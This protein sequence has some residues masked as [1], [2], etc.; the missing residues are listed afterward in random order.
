[1][2]IHGCTWHGATLRLTYRSVVDDVRNFG[3]Q[4]GPRGRGT[5]EIRGATIHLTDVRDAMPF[6]TGR[7]VVPGIGAMEALQLIGG[8]TR[9][10]LVVGIA[11]VFERYREDDGRFHGA[12]GPRAADSLDDV[13]RLLRA[14][15]AT[16]QA[17]LAIWRPTDAAAAG[18]VRDLPCT[19]SLQFF[20]RDGKLECHATMRSNDV[21]LGLAYDVFQFTQLQ[22]ALATSLGI[23]TGDYYHRPA[24][25]HL[26]DDD[27]DKVDD[28]KFV[29][30]REP[31][32]VGLRPPD[33]G[34]VDLFAIRRAALALL[35]GHA[36]PFDVGGRYRAWLDAGL[37]RN[38]A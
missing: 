24:S 19:L 28:L 4:V 9:P 34:A 29:E 27:D 7:G 33:G 6:G 22:L 31:M 26:Y 15:S 21:W 36:H 11:P 37:A 14:D 25:L 30:R 1:M 23:E 10:D 17:V 32:D 16:R 8:A 5:R 3:E 20:V 13:A 18:Y 38:S 35:D 2:S 12:Y